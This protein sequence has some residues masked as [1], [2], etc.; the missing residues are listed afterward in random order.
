ETNYRRALSSVPEPDRFEAEARTQAL[1]SST[2]YITAKHMR[3]DWPAYVSLLALPSAATLCS[4]V[5]PPWAFMWALSFSIFP[6]LKWMTW[7]KARQLFPNSAS[8][9]TIYLFAWPGMDAAAFL[10]PGVRT[11]RLNV[12]QWLPAI[13]KT[14]L[15]ILLLWVVARHVS[16]QLPLVRGWMGLLGL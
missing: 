5:V 9:S 14:V 12:Q 15:G 6:A 4:N 10:D 13:V 3:P 7:W 11:A 16:L 1:S 8:W 2:P